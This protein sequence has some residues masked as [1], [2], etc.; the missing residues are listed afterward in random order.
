M[1]TEIA[2][3]LFVSGVDDVRAWCEQ[4]PERICISCCSELA[5]VNCPFEDD[6]G[7]MA[8][9][10][11]NQ[12]MYAAQL[13][14]FHRDFRSVLIFCREGRNRSCLVAALALIEEGCSRS[15]ALQIVRDARGPALNSGM[16]LTNKYFVEL[17]ETGT[18]GI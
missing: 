7:G 18:T 14:H 11:Q 16:A 5:E 1:V 13:A 2:K 3:N 10:E 17:I 8:R 15:Q 9:A 6:I 4:H 12:A